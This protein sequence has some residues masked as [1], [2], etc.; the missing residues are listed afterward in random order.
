MK[1]TKGI[2]HQ[3]C[4]TLQIEGTVDKLAKIASQRALDYCSSLE[5][6]TTKKVMSVAG[7][8]HLFGKGSPYAADTQIRNHEL[9]SSHV[10][11]YPRM[12]QRGTVFC[13]R[14][15][16]LGKKT[17]S[18]CIQLT[19]GTYAIIEKIL[20]NNNSEACI[21]ARKLTCTPLKYTST[22]TRHLLKVLEEAEVFVVKAS[23][24]S[25]VC[26]LIQLEHTFVSP[27]PSSF[28]L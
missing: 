3:I 17:N 7:D 11:Q 9:L 20:C 6:A 21:M 25:T 13:D 28:V 24:V 8:V 1:A 27:I 10:R 15:H 16:A 26:V 19:D 18:S 22:V 4:R 14:K 12:V 23:N 2:P 5:R